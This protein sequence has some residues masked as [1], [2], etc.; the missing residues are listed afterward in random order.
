VA[1]FFKKNQPGSGFGCSI[2]WQDGQKN[3]HVNGFKNYFPS[4]SKPNWLLSIHTYQESPNQRLMDIFML[5]AD[6]FWF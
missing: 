2:A 1:F 6:R 4:Y 5:H 3:I